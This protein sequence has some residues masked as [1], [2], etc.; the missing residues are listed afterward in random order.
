M[1]TEWKW[2]VLTQPNDYPKERMRVLRTLLLFFQPETN[3]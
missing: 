1:L 3:C 2:N